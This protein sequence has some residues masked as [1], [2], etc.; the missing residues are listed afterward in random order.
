MFGLPAQGRRRSAALGSSTP[1]GQ[2]GDIPEELD[3]DAKSLADMGV[4]TGGC[5]VVDEKPIPV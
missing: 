3:D 5:I 2:E 1:P 4:V